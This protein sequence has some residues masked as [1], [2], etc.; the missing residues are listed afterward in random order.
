MADSKHYTEEGVGFVDAVNSDDPVAEARRRHHLASADPEQERQDGTLTG[1]AHEAKYGL[2]RAEAS[3]NYW[4]EVGVHP[5]ENRA[6]R[7]DELETTDA[8]RVAKK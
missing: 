3:A 6:L 4:R 1:P 5:I 7:A 2:D 8:P